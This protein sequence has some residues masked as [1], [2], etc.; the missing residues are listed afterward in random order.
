MLDRGCGPGLYT[1]RLAMLGHACTGIDFSPA[2]IRYAVERADEKGFAIDYRYEDVRQADYGGLYDL[3][4]MLFGEFNVFSEG[5]ARSIASKARH[6]LAAGGWLLLEH[7]TLDAVRSEGRQGPRWY[8]AESGV[9]AD[10]PHIVLEEH[11]WEEAAKTRRAV[12]WVIDAATG[13][14]AHYGETMRGY[15]QV[16]IVALLRACGFESVRTEETFPSHSRG[17]A[18]QTTLARRPL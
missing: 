15:E 11:T 8:S 5:D 10:E 16:E 9:F 12:Y 18:L 4:M 2:S 6:A 1:Q 13:R 14:V 3:V 7:Q 17:G